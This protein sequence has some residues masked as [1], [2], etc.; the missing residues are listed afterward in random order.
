MKFDARIAGAVLLVGSTMV[1]ALAGDPTLDDQ[2]S[3]RQEELDA[4]LDARAVQIDPG[5]LLEL[6]HDNLVRLRIVDVRDEGDFNAF[7][8]ADA[9]RVGCDDLRSRWGLALPSGTIVVIAGNDEARAEAAWRMLTARGVP[10][11]YVLEGGLNLWV[12]LY[13]LETVQPRTRYATASAMSSDRAEACF[14]DEPFRWAVGA[15]LGDRHPASLPALHAHPART[16]EVK[17]RR[18]SAGA[19]PSGGCG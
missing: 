12:E 18:A 8:L 3:W 15:A 5:E 11:V 10:N 19:R 9:E 2:L 16:F 17:V 14:Q 13:G 7:H 6:M 4:V 1:L